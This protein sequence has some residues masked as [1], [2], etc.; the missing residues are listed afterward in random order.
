[1]KHAGYENLAVYHG[2]FNDWISK[3]GKIIDGE[4]DKTR[5]IDFEQVKNGLSEGKFLLIDVRNP[6]ERI[7]P[8]YIPGTKNVPRK[9]RD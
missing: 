4:M 2:S 8:G 7:N 5:F 3:Q 6:K 9:Y 1:M